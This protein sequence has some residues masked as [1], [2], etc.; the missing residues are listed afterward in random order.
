VSCVVGWSI[1]A[2]MASKTTLK[3]DVVFLLQL[4]QLSGQV[5]WVASNSRRLMNA[6]RDLDAGLMAI[7]VF[8]QR[9]KP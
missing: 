4:L 1:S 2:R 6:P 5:L 3:L 8:K 9:P 7:S